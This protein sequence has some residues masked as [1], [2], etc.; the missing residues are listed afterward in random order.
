MPKKPTSRARKGLALGVSLCL[1]LSGRLAYASC[2]TQVEVRPGET[3]SDIANRCGITEGLILDLNP[4]VEGTRD[5]RAGMT[6]KVAR[7]GDESENLLLDRLSSYA[8]RAGKSIEGAARSAGESIEDFITRNPDLH[9]S[10]RRLGRSLSIPGLDGAEAQISLSARTGAPG[11]PVTLSAIGLPS[12]RLVDIAGGPPGGDYKL[13]QQARTSV[14]GT[15]Q[16][17]VELPDS[18]AEG[19]DF[20]FVIAIPGADLAVRSAKFD[21]VA[22]SPG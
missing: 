16:V 11:S 19:R 6:L 13:I 4:R 3:L 12:N 1:A 5:L 22:R 20:I 17:T 9:Q 14:E 2:G 18:A 7:A 8:E 21:V 15:L 10:V